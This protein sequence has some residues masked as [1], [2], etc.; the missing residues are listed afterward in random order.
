MNKKYY[1]S[2][3]AI[4]KNESMILKEW[5]EHYFFHGVDH[6]YMINDSSDDNYLEILNPY[7]SEKKITLFNCDTPKQ[8]KR[9]QIAYNTFFKPI[10]PETQWLAILDIDEYLYSP[11][12]INLKQILKEHENYASL[13]ANWCWF[14]SNGHVK[15]PHSVVAGFTKRAEY[16]APVFG[17]KPQEETWIMH[18]TDSYKSILNTS[19]ELKEIGIHGHLINGPHKNLSYISHPNDP[20]LLINHYSIQSREY[21]SKVKMPRGDADCHHSDSA[22]N[23]KWFESVNIGTIDDFRLLDQNKTILQSL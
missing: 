14:N 4:F 12:T 16:G 9:Q 6:I 23:W 8:K 2:V 3:G 7:I 15:Q 20:I 22:R 21:W 10:I 19:F 11:L 18:P 17:P 13:L 5:I 1:F